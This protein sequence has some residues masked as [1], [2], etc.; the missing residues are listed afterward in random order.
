MWVRYYV[1][2]IIDKIL[3]HIYGRGGGYHGECWSAGISMSFVSH[4]RL[5]SSI[6]KQPISA[7]YLILSQVYMTLVLPPDSLHDILLGLKI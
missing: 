7:L 3:S 5:R 4:L 6:A 2:S 1:F